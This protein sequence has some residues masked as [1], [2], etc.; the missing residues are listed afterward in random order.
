MLWCAQRASLPPQPLL[1]DLQ[2]LFPALSRT[3]PYQRVAG[4]LSVQEDV[5]EVADGD[6]AGGISTDTPAP[7][8]QSSSCSC[9]QWCKG[10][11][12]CTA[13]EQAANMRMR[14]WG[15]VCTGHSPWTRV[16]AR[17]P[18]ASPSTR[19][20]PGMRRCGQHGHVVQHL[21]R[22]TTPHNEINTSTQ[23]RHCH[24]S[25]RWWR[26][27]SRSN[28]LVQVRL[29]LTLSTGL[30]HTFILSVPAWELRV[31]VFLGGWGLVFDPV[32]GTR[33]AFYASI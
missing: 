33:R 26:L 8:L 32:G 31:P 24:R 28:N 29:L 16:P 6:S 18:C 5:A 15:W 25:S 10:G 23:P 1:P 27:L 4:P 19:S 14:V 2:C 12:H 7:A 21:C 11:S 30:P 17:S 20:S 22:P 9:T 13:T 3:L